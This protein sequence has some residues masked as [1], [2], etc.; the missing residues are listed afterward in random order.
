MAL[1]RTGRALG[2]D[3]SMLVLH[4]P[5]KES[6]ASAALDAAFLELERVE[7]VMSLYRPES[8]LARLNRDRVLENPH[9]SLVSVLRAAREMAEKSGGAFDV[10]VQPLWELYFAAMNR[11]RLP[12]AAEV[13]AARRKVDWRRVDISPARVRLGEGM[14][15]TLN[16]IAQGFA[17]DRAVEALRAHGIRHALANTGEIRALGPKQD[18]IPW[19]AGIQHPRA[20]DALAGIAELNGVCLSTSGDY[21]TPFTPDFVYNHIFD[22]ATGRSPL[23]LASVSATSPS[24]MTADALSTAL[25][26]MGIQR[27]MELI[28]SLPGSAALF[29]RK[30]LTVLATRDFPLAN[31]GNS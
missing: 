1:R 8:E 29:V 26:V 11:C 17:A 10:T 6:A 25:F 5:G 27:G 21:A 12:G 30:D 24:G 31:A 3:V 13:D 16:G 15:V 4:E 2:T 18:G 19:G 23:E 14:A 9:P 7:A 20:K 28:E 22:P